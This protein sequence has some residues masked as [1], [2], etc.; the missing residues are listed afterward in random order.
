[1]ATFSGPQHKHAM[2]AHRQRRREQAAQRQARSDAR[3][4]VEAYA[5]TRKQESQ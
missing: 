5:E 4:V 2:R 3:R 1:M